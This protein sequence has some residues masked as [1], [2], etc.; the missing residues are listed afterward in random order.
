MSEKPIDD[1][2]SSDL[3]K[4]H[5]MEQ[6]P[7]RGPIAESPLAH[8]RLDLV[9]SDGSVYINE[10]SLQ[11]HLVLRGAI[12]DQAFVSGVEQGLTLKLPAPLCS[13]VSGE[14][15][16]RW[17]SPNEWL[18]TC[19]DSET[20]RLEQSLRERIRGQHAIVNVSGGQTLISL[21]GKDAL[22][23]L[24]KS[25]SYDVGQKNFPIGKVVTTTFAK[26]QAVIRRTGNDDWELVIR[27]S[28]SDYIWRW[29]KDA[30][31]E[32]ISPLT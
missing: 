10:L 7:G 8:Y 14:V 30:S 21:S 20:F 18:I 15:S 1:T 12:E 3:P 28:F 5:V 19:P 26:T 24:K 31:A 23:V 22:N 9:P 27:R 6:Y 16:I 13:E 29:L 4:V 25:T 11:G 2:E 17:I 32:Y